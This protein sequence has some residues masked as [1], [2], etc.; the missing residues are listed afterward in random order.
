MDDKQYEE[1]T[2]A[3]QDAV[4]ADN[5]DVVYVP[6]VGPKPD[7]YTTDAKTGEIKEITRAE[8][9]EYQRKHV[10]VRHQ[11]VPM[12]GHKFVVGAQPR[13]RN[14]ESC[15]FAFFNVHGELTQSVEE[16]YAKHGGVPV[17]R[18]LG[19]ALLHNFLKFMSTVAALK[20]A[21]EAQAARSQEIK[22]SFIPPPAQGDLFDGSTSGTESSSTSSVED[23]FAEGSTDARGSQE[24]IAVFD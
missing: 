7:Y 22:D 15:W 23:V 9:K 4:A 16:L 10:T 1:S 24:G 3:E 20:Q 12:C 18:L 6:H 14:C 8:Y 2:Y 13:H 19:K 5:S 21:Q 11:R 17:S